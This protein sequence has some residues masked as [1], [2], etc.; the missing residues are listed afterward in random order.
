VRRDLDAL[1]AREHDLLIVGGGIYG[2]AAAWDAAQRGLAVALVERD[3]FGAGVSWNSLKTI[4]G[5]LRYL[6]KADLGRMRESIRERR[7]LLRIAP[8]LVRPLPFLVPTY[9]HG[10]AGRE[11]LLVALALN[12]LISHDRND[13]LSETHRIPRGRVL[14]RREVLH[15]LPGLA[16]RGLT[17]GGLWCDAQVGSSERLTVAFV[18]A[19]AE[20]GAAVA[21]H[22][23][24]AGLL[25]T[26]NRVAGVRARDALN[27]RAVDVQARVVLNAAGPALDRLL[28]E[29]GIHRPA[30]PLLRARNLVF[31]RTPSVP[32]AVGARSGGRF[33]F[34]VPWGDRTMVGTAYAPAEAATDGAVAA[35]R[36][37]AVRAF[38]WAGLEAAPLALVHEG[39]VPGRGG[40][41]GLSSRV[42]LHDH[43]A[44]DGVAGLV[45]VQGVK[46][47]TARGVAE[48][49]IDLVFRR[50]GWRSPTCRT[51]ETPLLRARPLAGTLEE[52]AA[53]A[54]R[55][56]MALTLEDAVLRR[57][58]L[59]TA[60]A[61]ASAD[62]D[63]V[64]G[65]MGPMLGWDSARE[66]A[67]RTALAK[68]FPPT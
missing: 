39:L 37:E 54:V 5:G 52:R 42:R 12:D 18:H 38:P 10:I 31:A 15:R 51:A 14:S 26:A 32:F 56:E 40:A 33:L 49:A 41:A 66:T 1:A 43:E 4:H 67:E 21:N 25:R 24:A 45:S 29:A 27:G 28:A 8:A 47:T 7:A 9:G 17:G 60:G 57:L 11:A 61:P 19:A 22:V 20:A 48:K 34:L 53:E 13:G 23:E 50:L 3:D 30:A 58:D 46:Y 59:G 35:F 36:G 62:V 55:A 68:R 16:E 44:E 65:T 2:A 6:K 63:A 64:V